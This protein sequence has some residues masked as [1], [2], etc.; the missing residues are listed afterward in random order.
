MKRQV[1]SYGLARALIEQ[2]IQTNIAIFKQG[3]GQR[4]SGR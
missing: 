2:I 4:V 3:G 1:A